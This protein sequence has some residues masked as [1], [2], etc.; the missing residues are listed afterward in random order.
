MDGV[1]PLIYIYIDII[2][3]YHNICIYIYI[4]I[5]VYT[6]LPIFRAPIT[7]NLS[8]RH[9]IRELSRQKMLLGMASPI[10]SIHVNKM[11]RRGWPGR[12]GGESWGEM[13]K[14]EVKYHA[15]CFFGE[16]SDSKLC[17]TMSCWYVGDICWLCF[18][19]RGLRLQ[20]EGR[21]QYAEEVVWCVIQI[22]MLRACAFLG[23]IYITICKEFLFNPVSVSR[24]YNMQSHNMYPHKHIHV[25]HICSYIYILNSYRSRAI[26]TITPSLRES[27]QSELHT[28]LGLERPVWVFAC[29]EAKGGHPLK[30]KQ[31]PESP[32]RA[33][34]FVR[35]WSIHFF[36][37]FRLEVHMKGGWS[38]IWVLR[39]DGGRLQ[40]YVFFTKK[41]HSTLQ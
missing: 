20:G 11:K 30:A 6:G 3:N 41:A 2:I 21:V 13:M 22:R 4:Y 17:I 12:P 29:T 27:E 24:Y 32:I 7:T 1:S 10:A 9:Y 31:V 36:V 14:A 34:F 39:Q 33:V 15:V 28:V 5:Y 37:I 16:T 40:T 19:R 26:V 35:S 38:W 23:Y 18:S 8:A 25:L